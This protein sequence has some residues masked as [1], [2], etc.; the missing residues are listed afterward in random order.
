M[1]A[2]YIA[3]ISG[4]STLGGYE[5]IAGDRIHQQDVNAPIFKHSTY[6]IV[7]DMLMLYLH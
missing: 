3:C 7:A 4:D 5:H 1:V 2:L 6:G